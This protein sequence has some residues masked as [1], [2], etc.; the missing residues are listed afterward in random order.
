MNF[1]ASFETAAT[2]VKNEIFLK[3]ARRRPLLLPIFVRDSKKKKHLG[4]N[5]A[6][7]A[8]LLILLLSTQES[9]EKNTKIVCSVRK[10]TGKNEGL[11][12]LVI[13]P[14]FWRSKF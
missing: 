4:S 11:G 14:N 9:M 3:V 5:Y 2:F 10:R 13:N 7:I 8:H 12:R 1:I 6:T